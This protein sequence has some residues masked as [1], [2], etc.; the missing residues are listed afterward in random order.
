MSDEK[1]KA[2]KE[3]E[4]VLEYYIV[5]APWG[6]E[7]KCLF[8]EDKT[9]EEVESADIAEEL[10]AHNADCLVLHARNFMKNN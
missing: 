9:T 5:E 6:G 10:I 1:T 2:Y 7:F 8:C 4:R 3:A